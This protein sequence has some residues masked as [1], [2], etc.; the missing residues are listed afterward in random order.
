M[1]T[2]RNILSNFL[3][4]HYLEINTRSEKAFLS[5]GLST[6]AIGYS[7]QPKPKPPRQRVIQAPQQQQFN[8]QQ[9]QFNQVQTYGQ[10]LLCLFFLSPLS[11]FLSRS[12]SLIHFDFFYS[13]TEFYPCLIFTL[14]LLSLIL[15]I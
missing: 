3:T 1:Y 13:S 8:N 4:I 15:L 2:N 5:L 9:Q 11:L 12:L 7:P 6:P 10:V 14:V